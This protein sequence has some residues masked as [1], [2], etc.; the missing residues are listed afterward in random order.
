MWT[1]TVFRQGGELLDLVDLQL[2]AL[3]AEAVA[4]LFQ[5]IHIL[6][7]GEA[8]VLGYAVVVLTPQVQ[9]PN[10]HSKSPSSDSLSQLEARKLGKRMLSCPF[11]ISYTERWHRRSQMG[12]CWL[13]GSVCLRVF[14]F[15]TLTVQHIVLALF[16]D[17]RVQTQPPC[18]AFRMVKKALKSP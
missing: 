7:L 8:R 9:W 1:L 14:L 16:C 17:G 3:G 11:H 5:E 2:S 10:A 6:M 18:D 13:E 12:G 15:W 4:E